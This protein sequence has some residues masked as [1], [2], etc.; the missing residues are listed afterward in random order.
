MTTY[1]NLLKKHRVKIIW[2]PI[3]VLIFVICETTQPYFMSLI[4]DQGIMVNDWTTITKVGIAMIGISL[5]S[6][7]ANLLNIYI[8]SQVSVQFGTGLRNQ[9]FNKIQTIST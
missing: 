4:I 9:L 2:S 3:L 7:V 6:L 8:S 5:I 1:K